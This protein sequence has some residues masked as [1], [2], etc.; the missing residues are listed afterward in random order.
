MPAIGYPFNLL[1]GL[2]DF[3]TRFFADSAQLE[4]L[5]DGAAIL[6][7][8]AY[9]DL[10]SAVLGVSLADAPALDRE[11]WRMIAIREDQCRFRQG[12][13]PGEDRWEVALP[14]PVA[15]I[16]ALDNRVIEPTASL[17]ERRD[18]EIA[19]RA[20]RFKVDPTDPG[21]DGVPLDGF[22]RRAVDVAVGGRFVDAG[23][24]DWRAAGVRK[25]DVLRLLDVGDDGSQRRRSDHE[26]VV[27]RAAALHVSPDA[28]LPAPAS[29]IRYAI[30]RAPADPKAFDQITLSGT[31]GTL[32][33]TRLV[34]GS[35]RL[36]ARA[37]G[38][39]DVAEG[40][41]YV[42]NH[43]GGTLE[44]IS[45]A[46]WQGDPGPY[47]AAYEWSIEIAFGMSGAIA[48]TGGVARVVQIAAWAPDALVD[49][50]T[51]S[52]NFGSLIGR[53][54]ASSEAY[55]AFLQG[56]FQLYLAGPVLAR[57]ESA[58]NV[59]LGLPVAGE[60][61]EVVASIDASDPV[62]DRVVATRPSTGQDVAYD[63]PKGTPLRPDLAPG[64]VLS[65]F[66][67]ISAAVTVT[68]YVETPGWWHG[69]VIPSALF[70]APAPSA[71]RRT[72]SP[73][74]VAHV[75][76]AA[77]GAA[78]GDPGLHVGADDT[79]FIP[80]PGHPVLRRRLAF[81]LMDRYLKHHTFVVRF[82][83][84]AL[85]AVAGSDPARSIRDMNE[86]VIG[87]RPSHTYAFTAP[88]TFFRDEITVSDALSFAR[89]VG[90]AVHGP[91]QVVFADQTPAFGDGVWSFGDYFAYE[92][93]SA[94]IA[95][96]AL[97]TPVA[98]P[99]PPAPPRSGRLV[100]AHVGAARLGRRVVEN[101]D[102]A[103]DYAA[104]TVARLTAWDA[105]TATVTF[106]QL[107]VGNVADAPGGAGDMPLLAGG[108]DPA[109]VTA[110]FDPASAQW[111]GT[112]TPATAP[113]DIG[114]VERA[115][116]VR[117]HS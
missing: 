107:S 52:N 23:V 56:I 63:F 19:G 109:I 75:F 115:L 70:G 32:A 104:R 91:D 112:A 66:E 26:I 42:V 48:A 96:P 61:G 37:A 1:Q 98:L 47:G 106:V 62:V 72:A 90:S 95:F 84:A 89:Q 99:D 21:G 82:D 2:S 97:A 94:T 60:D 113:R 13:V 31:S 85:S 76:G 92:T 7:G 51:L 33:R 58:L 38:G 6:V 64:L 43:E 77:D 15:A 45:G 49:R 4:S 55:R 73:A 25:G 114:M 69:A 79:G 22:A 111:D 103:V 100:R 93:R 41:D 57:V 5:Y 24:A 3:W 11:Y 29:G 116:V 44:R 46:P 68:D 36:Y 80:A 18:F 102:Y 88:E 71:A 74:H 87:A 65:S 20:A 16:T 28:P 34:E 12:R 9:L 110:E 83:A 78:F 54:G 67:P 17:E 50:R 14:D 53:E 27:V 8:Q 30:V 117:A 105:A 59:V 39:G 108:V 10:L 86:L 40:V 101:L 81:V 35:L